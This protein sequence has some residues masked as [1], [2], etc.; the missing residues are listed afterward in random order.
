VQKRKRMLKGETFAFDSRRID[1]SNKITRRASHHGWEKQLMPRRHRC[2]EG[3]YQYQSLKETQRRE[4]DLG[5]T[6]EVAETVITNLPACKGER[7]LEW[8]RFVFGKNMQNLQKRYASEGKDAPNRPRPPG[9]KRR[10][11]HQKG[12]TTVGHER[13]ER[14]EKKKGK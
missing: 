9:E 12:E 13:G 1:R 7:R 4:G 14:F 5:P 11:S 3:D 6:K 2:R 8:T 10:V